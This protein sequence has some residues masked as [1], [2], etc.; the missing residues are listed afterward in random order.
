LIVLQGERRASFRLVSLSI[1]RTESSKS[2]E[3]STKREG[4]SFLST[5]RTRSSAARLP[6]RSG[7]LARLSLTLRGRPWC[8]EG[9]HDHPATAGRGS[10]SVDDFGEDSPEPGRGGAGSNRL[11]RAPG[12]PAPRRRRRAAGPRCGAVRHGADS[13]SLALT[14]K[15]RRSPLFALR[16]ARQD[17]PN[18]KNYVNTVLAPT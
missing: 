7:A 1:F 16:Q 5:D 13:R 17:K 3:I 15:G 18:S 2:L 11:F 10:R 4:R 12:Q 8:E 14:P 6:G 9:R